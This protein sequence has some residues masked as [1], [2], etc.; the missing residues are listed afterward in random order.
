MNGGQ[1]W[2]AAYF[3]SKVYLTADKH[4]QVARLRMNLNNEGFYHAYY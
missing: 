3:Q 1:Q 2:I 4:Q